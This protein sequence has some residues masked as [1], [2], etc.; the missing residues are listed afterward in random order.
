MITEL[1]DKYVWLIQTFIDAGPKGLLLEQIAGKWSRRYGTDY[2][3]R[4]FNNHREA[5]AEIFGIEIECDRSTNRY[6]IRYG[7][8]AIDR[9]SSV[10]WLINTFTVNNL[11]S[12]SK[13]RLTG[14]VSLENI[15][16]GQVHLTGI[17]SA[18]QDDR[19]LEIVYRKYGEPEGEMFHVDPYAIK[20]YLRRWYVLGYCHERGAERVYA[21]DRINSLAVTGW[22]FRM[23]DDYE[24]DDLYAQTIGIYRNDDMEPESIYLKVTE[25]EANFLRDL[26]L[27]SSQ[28]EIGPEGEGYVKFRIRVIPNG[29]L[30]MELKR[31]CSD[32]EVL[33][34]ASLRNRIARELQEAA[35]KYK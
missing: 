2:P 7:E 13:E 32:V 30:I 6:F 18:M 27:H 21:L 11:L 20:E 19:T 35:D 33:S 4:T 3:R 16:S 26:P 25:R 22:T 14:R 15:P 29:D 24:I 9:Q 17:I 23:P 5:I 1:I 10:G 12:L 28:M 34:P 8:D 31:L